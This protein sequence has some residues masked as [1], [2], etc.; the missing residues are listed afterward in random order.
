MWIWQRL[1]QHQCVKMHDGIKIQFFKKCASILLRREA[2]NEKLIHYPLNRW[3]KNTEMTATCLAV[4][5]YSDLGL[6]LRAFREDLELEREIAAN[7]A[8]SKSITRKRGE[9]KFIE[10]FA[11]IIQTYQYLQLLKLFALTLFC[12]QDVI[13]QF[14]C[15]LS[16]AA[17]FWKYCV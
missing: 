4:S 8:E 3:C 1:A 2:L 7:L 15:L 11:C 17:C 6:Q 13:L 16:S 14:F 12:I 10:Y 9:R 5:K